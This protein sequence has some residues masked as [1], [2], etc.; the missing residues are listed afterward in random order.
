[1]AYRITRQDL[2]RDLYIAFYDARRHKAKMSY[3]LHFEH[4]LKDNL[5]QLCDSLFNR[6]YS[7]LPS[8]CF[9][10]DHPKKREVFA[11]QFADRV[12]H[13]LYYNYTHELFERTFIQDSYSCI[14]G[15]GTHY[16][17]KRMYEHVRKESLNYTVPCYVLKLDIRGYFMHINRQR[18]LEIATRTLMKMSKHKV[19]S[20]QPATWGDIIDIDFV[21]WLTK[22]IVLLDPKIS[23]EIVGHKS[24]WDG[25]DKNK[26]L[27]YTPE[28][29]GLPIGNLTSQL[30][31][32]IYMNE[33]DQFM[34]RVMHCTHYGRYVDDSCT[35]GADREWLLSL[36]PHA[37]QFLDKELGLQLHRG[38]IE[39][40]DVYRGFEF[41]GAFL[42]PYRIYISNKS[43]A[44]ARTRIS[45]LDMSAHD[46][47]CRTVNSYLGMM[48]HYSSYNLRRE[49]FYNEKF[50]SIAPLDEGLTKM[51]FTK[52]KNYE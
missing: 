42:K 50:I 35:A 28:G 9:I 20:E 21:L 27:F 47:V 18:L 39:I 8:K 45:Q 4:H 30:F 33:F 40:C 34:K 41:L 32:N 26:S 46:K 17:I 7:P 5:E 38:K 14:A 48:S 43:L 2:L 23:C 44:R 6:T 12:V 16:G 1:M 36:I 19:V 37:D 3:V 15:R 52:N 31:S 13:H 10:V 11:A 22:E 51:Y 49:I 29:C 25:L 24:D